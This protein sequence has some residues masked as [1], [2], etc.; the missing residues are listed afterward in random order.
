MFDSKLFGWANFRFDDIFVIRG[1]SCAASL[2]QPFL[3][4]A[5]TFMASLL[6]AFGL[7]VVLIRVVALIRERIT[8]VPTRGAPSN[9]RFCAVCP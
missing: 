5:G 3:G 6:G 4:T 1:E 7:R 8:R 9:F 2:L